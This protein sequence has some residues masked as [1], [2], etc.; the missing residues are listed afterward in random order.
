MTLRT[1]GGGEAGE[2]EFE[3]IVDLGDCPDGRACG[4]DIVRLLDGDGRRDALDAVDARFVHAVEELPRV[5]R[6]GFDVAALALGIDGVESEG[7]LARAARAGDDMEESAREIEI[8]AA[9]VV[10]ARTADAE[11]VLVGRGTL[12]VGHAG[13]WP[14]DFWGVRRRTGQD[15]GK[16]ASGNAANDDFC[17]GTEK[18]AVG[19]ASR[20]YRREKRRLRG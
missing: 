6:E 12:A 15:R 7:R 16:R 14:A 5:G 3:V 20:P 1:R 19:W 8:D 13:E 10:L 18:A 9:E 17:P 2:E 4:F 11:D